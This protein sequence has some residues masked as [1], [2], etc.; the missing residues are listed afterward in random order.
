MRHFPIPCLAHMHASVV[1]GLIGVLR[2][3]WTTR[4]TCIRY[5]LLNLLKGSNE[6]YLARKHIGGVFAPMPAMRPLHLTEQ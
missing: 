6:P 5:L 3:S 2:L 4:T 1:M